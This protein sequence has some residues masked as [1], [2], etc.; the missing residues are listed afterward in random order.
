MIRR[1]NDYHVAPTAKQTSSDDAQKSAQAFRYLGVSQPSIKPLSEDTFVKTDKPFAVE[2]TAEMFDKKTAEFTACIAYKRQECKE[3]YESV[4]AQITTEFKENTLSPKFF[5][6]L[7][8]RIEKAKTVGEL[9]SLIRECENYH[10][11]EYEEKIAPN[12]DLIVSRNCLSS[13]YRAAKIITK[14]IEEINKFKDKLMNKDGFGKELQGN[15]VFMAMYEKNNRN[16]CELAEE[17]VETLEDYGIALMNKCEVLNVSYKFSVQSAEMKLGE[18][19]AKIYDK[20]SELEEKEI[21]GN[22]FFEIGEN[23]EPMCLN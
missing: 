11:S 14:K 23:I 18:C 2:K 6:N 16:L 5:E 15:K 21:K 10:E 17:S 8:K 19:L 13:A 9:Q 1:T 4:L 20:L 12:G 7:L 3:V 22:L